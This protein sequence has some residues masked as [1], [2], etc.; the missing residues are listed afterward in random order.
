[1]EDSM[2]RRKR[3]RGGWRRKAVMGRVQKGSNKMKDRKAMG[4]DGIENE[5]WKY[6]GE[7]VKEGLWEICRKVWKGEGWLEN[8]IYSTCCK[9]GGRRKCRRL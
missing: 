4:G 6:G 1:M 3:G 8:R 2:G 7:K 9:E 5:I